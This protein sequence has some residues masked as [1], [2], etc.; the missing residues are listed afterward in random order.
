MPIG[1][2]RSTQP[3]ITSIA[4]TIAWN[5]SVSVRGAGQLGDGEGEGQAEHRQRQ[6]LRRLAAAEMTFDW[7]DRLEEIAQRR[8][9]PTGWALGRAMRKACDHF[10]GQR[11]EIEQQRHDQRGH[12]GR[13]H[14]MTT[15]MITERNAIRPARAALAAA[16][17][18]VTSR[19]MISGTI[20]ICSPC[21]QARPI[22]WVTPWPRPPVAGIERRRRD[23]G[24]Q[25]GDQRQQDPCSLRHA[26][27]RPLRRSQR[28]DL[29]AKRPVTPDDPV[30]VASVSKLVVAIGVLRLVEQGRLD[31]DADVS[32]L[33]GR[34]LRN[35]AFPDTPITLRLLLSHRSSLTDTVDYV[36][37]LDADMAG[38]LADPRAWDA[39]HAPGAFFRY[40]N[41]NFPVIAAVLERATGERFDRLMD[42]LVLKPLA[43]DACYNWASCAPATAARAAVIYRARQPT[44]DDNQGIAPA[45]A[46]TPATDGSCDLGKWHAGANGAIFSP[47]GGLRI[48]ARGLARIGR[49]LLNNGQARRRPPAHPQIGRLARNPALDLRRRQRRHQQRLLLQLR[50]GDDL[51]PHCPPRLPRR[52][53]RRFAPAPRPWRRSLWP[54][55]GPVARSQGR[56]RNRLFRHRRARHD[57]HSL[58]LHSRRGNAGEGH[59]MNLR[60]IEIFHAVYVNGSVSGAARA[61]NVSQPSVSKMLRHAESLLGF[62][63]FQRTNGRLV[64]TEDAHTLFTEVRRSRTASM[65]CARRARIC[66]AGRGACC[67]CRRCPASR[68]RRC[69]PRWRGSCKT[70][71][72]VK[73]DLQT[74]HHDDLLRKLFERE[75]D[76]A[77]AY[78]VPPAA[79]IDHKP[80]GEGELVVFYR[81]QDMP[82]APARCDMTCLKGHRFISLATSGPMGQLFTQE[83]QRQGSCSTT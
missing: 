12:Q 78:E 70:H 39:E 22:G 73:F 75:T 52:S 67:G 60:H 51:P 77:I 55:L 37:P 76:I 20:T 31:L 3:M 13:V 29:A 10:G 58:G 61:L 68:C 33:L 23:P 72:N 1:A 35:P 43:L 26:F 25:P 64:P 66:A 53:V 71:D 63:L 38:V 7:H 45:C 50:P 34:R 5:S 15:N 19:P 18:P 21:S 83:L 80:L 56:H 74:V 24:Q 62:Q 49:L 28:A 16:P 27:P 9:L 40:T 47:Q 57:R 44:K 2:S 30:R 41:F 11:P 69:R 54:A 81:E 4:S 46:V 14:R 59:A 48:S 6:E 65:R 79:P 17:T 36:L 42:R 32:V 8:H 82:D